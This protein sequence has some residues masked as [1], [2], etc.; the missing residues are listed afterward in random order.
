MKKLFRTTARVWREKHQLTR[1]GAMLILLCLLARGFLEPAFE[2]AV[3]DAARPTAAQVNY[4]LGIFTV[5][6]SVL[7]LQVVGFVLVGIG[8]CLEIRERKRAL[9][10]TPWWRDR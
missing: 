9:Y 3:A 5:L 2:N 6:V 7:T 10:R 1:A 8:S 4:F